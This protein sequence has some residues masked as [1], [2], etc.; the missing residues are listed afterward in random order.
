MRN[1]RL[2]C[3]ACAHIAAIQQDIAIGRRGLADIGQLGSILGDVAAEQRAIA[4]QQHTSIT[5]RNDMD[6]TYFAASGQSLGDLLHTILAAVKQHDFSV[7]RNGAKQLLVVRCAGIDKYDFA[8]AS[9][10]SGNVSVSHSLMQKATM[11][12]TQ[13]HRE[14][15]YGHLY[16][17][18]C[19]HAKCIYPLRFD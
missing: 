3:A 14:W 11:D 1:E 7:R 12:W 16:A 15:R 19:K 2:S 13:Q 4:K 17:K 9:A 8:R 5:V 6:G 10:D 18:G